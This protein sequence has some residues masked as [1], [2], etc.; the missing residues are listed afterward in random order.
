MKNIRSIALFNL[1]AIIIYT[2]YCLIQ[3]SATPF[4]IDSDIFH[5]FNKLIG[6]HPLFARFVAIVNNRLFDIISFLVMGGLYYYYF[7]P[8]P[9]AKKREMIVLGIMMLLTAVL[10]KQ[11]GKFMMINHVSPSLFFWDSSY[12]INDI[13]SISTKDRSGDSFPSDHGSFL[14]IFA[15]Y[16]WRYFGKKTLLITIPIVI[17]FSLPRIMIGAHWF[18]DIYIGSLSLCCLVLSWLLLTPTINF[19][20]QKLTPFIPNYFFI[21]S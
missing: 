9:V 4:I 8:Q 12:H 5:F 11:C 19:C 1:L 13:T 2:F 15:A 3:K 16:L 18:S 20:V 17:I 21:K 10:I 6:K 14:M 7:R